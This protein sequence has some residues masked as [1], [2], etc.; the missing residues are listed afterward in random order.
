MQT[1]TNSTSKQNWVMLFFTIDG[2]DSQRQ[3]DRDR[4]TERQT[5]RWT[6]RQTEIDRQGG[7]RTDRQAEAGGRTDGQTDRASQTDDGQI[8]G[9]TDRQTVPVGHHQQGPAGLSVSSVTTASPRCSP[10]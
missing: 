6:D 9:Q 3:T 4:Q 1:A 5:D 2:I 10:D 8:D 7:R